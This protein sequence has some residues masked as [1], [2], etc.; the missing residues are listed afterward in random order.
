M[1]T[2]VK[3]SEKE[4]LEFFGRIFGKDAGLLYVEHEWNE[5]AKA[6]SLEDLIDCGWGK[7]YVWN[8]GSDVTFFSRKSINEEFANALV[9]FIEPNYVNKDQFFFPARI[10]EIINLCPKVL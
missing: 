6:A 7:I 1:E 3:M 9:D 2:I 4:Y 10:I 5:A 8:T